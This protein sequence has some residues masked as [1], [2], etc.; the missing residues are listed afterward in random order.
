MQKLG[1]QGSASSSIRG[2]RKTLGHVET[3][4][5]TLAGWEV[6]SVFIEGSAPTSAELPGRSVHTSLT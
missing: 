2:N 6:L 5:Y 4:T 1:K 3:V